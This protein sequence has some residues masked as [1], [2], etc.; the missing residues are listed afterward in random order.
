MTEPELLAHADA[1][2]AARRGIPDR[3]ME[4]IRRRVE[5]RQGSG[6]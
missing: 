3:L 5:E 2:L 4:R 6:D 1:V